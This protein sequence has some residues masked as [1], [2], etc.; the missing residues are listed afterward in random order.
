MRGYLV[1]S[2]LLLAWWNSEHYGKGFLLTGV[3]LGLSWMLVISQ[4]WELETKTSETNV[5]RCK[6]WS[7][8]YL[9]VIPCFMSVWSRLI[10]K[11]KYCGS[12]QTGNIADLS[13]SICLSFCMYYHVPWTHSYTYLY[14][15][16]SYRQHSHGD[17]TCGFTCCE[18]PHQ[19]YQ[20]LLYLIL[21]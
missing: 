13:F 8:L 11:Q 1:S 7:Y 3:T 19:P 17:P 21:G 12:W 5:P 6:T 14:Y 4:V 20:V 9:T 2:P 16:P 15:S 10:L 18:L